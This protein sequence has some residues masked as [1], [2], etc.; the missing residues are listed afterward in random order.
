MK[1]FDQRWKVLVAEAR[2]APSPPVPGVPL[3]ALEPLAPRR[4]G[5]LLQEGQLLAALSFAMVLGC[6]GTVFLGELVLD[7]RGASALQ[8]VPRPPQLPRPPSLPAP[9]SFAADAKAV[10]TILDKESTP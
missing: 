4:T 8:G 5:R 3:P 6:G 10:W 9:P 2:R 1:G 7:I